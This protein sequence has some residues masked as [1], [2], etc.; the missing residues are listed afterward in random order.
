MTVKPWRPNDIAIA[1]IVSTD[2]VPLHLS[3]S[4]GALRLHRDRRGWCRNG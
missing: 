1:I 3:M 4:I 2:R